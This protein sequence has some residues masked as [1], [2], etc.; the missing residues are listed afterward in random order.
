ML[1]LG[2]GSARILVM[3]ER[4]EVVIEIERD[5]ACAHDEERDGDGHP[6]GRCAHVPARATEPSVDACPEGHYMDAKGDALH[7]QRGQL[8]CCNSEASHLEG[9]GG[10]RLKFT[11]LPLL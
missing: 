2:I 4:Y 6:T 10:A 11:P 7:E 9:G 3:S 8:G 5:V 1:E